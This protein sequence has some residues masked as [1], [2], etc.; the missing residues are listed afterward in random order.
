ME[1]PGNVEITPLKEAKYVEVRGICGESGEVIMR[2]YTNLKENF[3]ISLLIQ[4]WKPT[5]RL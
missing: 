4:I 3:G 2:E 5:T 1:V